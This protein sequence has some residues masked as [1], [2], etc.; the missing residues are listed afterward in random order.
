MRARVCVWRE[1]GLAGGEV[2]RPVPARALDA[3]L[4]LE[5]AVEPDR[6]VEGADLMHEVVAQLR[7]ER[8]GVLGGREVAAL[9]LAGLAQ[10][11]GDAGDDLAHRFLG[12][13]AGGDAGFAEILGDGHVGSELRPV[14]GDLGVVHLEDDLAVGAGDPGGAP[15]PLDRVEHLR[16]G[17]PLAGHAARDRK[18]LAPPARLALRRRGRGLRLRCGGCGGQR[19]LARRTSRL[20]HC[21]ASSEKKVPRRPCG[22]R[23]RT[24]LDGSLLRPC[25]RR[26]RRFRLPLRVR[27]PRRKPLAPRSAAI[28]RGYRRVCTG[29]KGLSS[30]PH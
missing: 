9:L 30:D 29:S 10:G 7:L 17:L 27:H 18:A 20:C 14:G 21:C 25:D 19:F 11:V 2:H 8:L 15:G 16:C 3:V 6:A 4:V 26:L 5:A 24:G 1:I 12:A 13:A 28:S 22:H 23:L